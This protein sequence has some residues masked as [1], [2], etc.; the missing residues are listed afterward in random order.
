MSAASKRPGPGE[1]PALEGMRTR[2]R[3]LTTLP[4]E[5]DLVAGRVLA[6]IECGLIV[7]NEGGGDGTR[8]ITPQCSGWATKYGARVLANIKYGVPLPPGVVIPEPK[9][10]MGGEHHAPGPGKPGGGDVPAGVDD[11]VPPAAVVAEQVVV[12]AVLEFE[13]LPATPVVE[14]AR[15]WVTCPGGCGVLRDAHHLSE[16]SCRTCDAA[17]VTEDRPGITGNSS[18]R[19]SVAAAMTLPTGK[20]RVQVLNVL[21]R[22]RVDGRTAEEL[23]TDT[24][25]GGS[26][27]RPRLLELERDGFVERTDLTR[28]TR[29]GMRAVC[30]A[31]T[32]KGSD[33]NDRLNGRPAGMP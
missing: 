10:S 26:T 29:S 16:E 33:A 21:A 32:A 1:H 17:R 22:H 6:C 30:W 24:G 3:T 9:V 14:P 2:E 28:P 8:C 4:T 5:A 13:P 7:D 27:I 11:G 12:A 19:T 20:R 23:E 18:P 31:V 15:E 25:L